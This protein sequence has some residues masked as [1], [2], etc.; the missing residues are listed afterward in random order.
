MVAVFSPLTIIAHLVRFRAE[1]RAADVCP[2]LSLFF[3]LRWDEYQNNRLLATVWF[4]KWAMWNVKCRF[5]FSGSFCFAFDFWSKSHF[6]L[7]A[8]IAGVGVESKSLFKCPT[9]VVSC[10]VINATNPAQRGTIV[11]STQKKEKKSI[12][13]MRLKANNWSWPPNIMKINRAMFSP[14]VVLYGHWE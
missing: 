2:S 3:H 14:W 5:Y 11:H 8:F 4:V 1:R 7:V 9:L 12:I 13:Q 10:R 6:Q